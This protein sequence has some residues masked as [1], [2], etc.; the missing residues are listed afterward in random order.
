MEETDVLSLPSK[1]GAILKVVRR[2][3]KNITAYY[4]REM[5]FLKE[6][7]EVYVYEL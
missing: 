3:Y 7:R 1:Q 4:N 5:L 2:I 6:L